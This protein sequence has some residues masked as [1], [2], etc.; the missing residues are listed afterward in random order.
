[1]RWN[2]YLV[3][4]PSIRQQKLGCYL[5]CFAGYVPQPCIKC[6]WRFPYVRRTAIISGLSWEQ[7]FT[8]LAKP[9]VPQT[10]VLVFFDLSVYLHDLQRVRYDVFWILKLRQIGNELIVGFYL[11]WYTKKSNLYSFL[12]FLP[13]TELDRYLWEF[14]KS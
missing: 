5:K 10:I 1:M 14:S 8:Y 6:H 12:T 7:I 9:S 11:P 4:S 3:G 2:I 13:Y